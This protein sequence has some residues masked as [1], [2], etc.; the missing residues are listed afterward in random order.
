MFKRIFPKQF[1]NTYR[2]H[3]FGI[4]LLGVVA[5]MK[6]L[7][8]AVSVF[9]TRN[10]LIGA[11]GIPLDSCGAAG[12]E[13]VIALTALLGLCLLVIALQCVV[14]LVRYR[15]MIPLMLLIQLIVQIG[16]RVLMAVNPITRSSEPSV[17]YAGHPIGFYV[18]LAILAVTLI[19]FALSLRNNPPS[20]QQAG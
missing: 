13:T 3:W 7:Q 8:G 11:D 5:T 6:G 17:S 2:G 19:G 18:N 9:D 16:G 12:I 1:D 10:V 20:A 4:W 15:A 14:V